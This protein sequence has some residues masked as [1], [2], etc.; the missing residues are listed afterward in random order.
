MYI[1][2]ENQH[3]EYYCL[4]LFEHSLFSLYSLY[5]WMKPLK[6]YK[7]NKK[8]ALGISKKKRELRNLLQPFI[9]VLVYGISKIFT[10][11]LGISFEVNIIGTFLFCS[12]IFLIDFFVI[13]C[14]YRSRRKKMEDN[15]M[16]DKEKSIIVLF[17]PRTK[18]IKFFLLVVYPILLLYFIYFSLKIL[19]FPSDQS[20]IA[21]LCLILIIVLCPYH[22][23]L[24]CEPYYNG[25]KL[26]RCNL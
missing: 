2:Y 3:G 18:L 17:E 1:Q 19:R 9:F 11:D 22:S 26:K 15:I 10:F 14:F 4:D 25:E 23:L 6:L 12:L 7:S 21:S 24:L 20:I 5:F 13:C 16:I 8:F